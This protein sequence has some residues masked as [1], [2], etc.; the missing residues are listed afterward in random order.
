MRKISY[1]AFVVFGL[2]I[3]YSGV[4]FAVNESSVNQPNNNPVVVAHRGASSVAPEN[5]LSAFTKAIE[6]GADVVELDVHLSKDGEV[7]VIHDHSVDRTTDGTGDIEH[8]TLAELKKL[9][10][11]SWFSNDFAE[12]PVPTLREALELVNGRA[13]VLVEI[14]WPEKGLYV[15]IEKKI[16]K[17]VREL[18]A[19]SWVQY[20][21]FNTNVVENLLA[22]DPKLPVYKLIVGKLPVLPVYYDDGFRLGNPIRKWKG[23]VLGV[24]PNQKFAGAH[25]I[26]KAH[27]A[28][29]VVYTWTVNEDDKMNQLKQRGIDGIIS[30][31][32]QKLIEKSNSK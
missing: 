4:V 28:G 20:Q 23:R 10:A 21:S 24:N 13:I 15:G 9:D 7:I 5:T 30:N 19:E 17:L 11:G 3:L 12:E 8:L 18:Q 1:V 32:P 2:V 22:I 31:Y 29:L 16:V 14:K 27:Q 6:M 25:F 26:K